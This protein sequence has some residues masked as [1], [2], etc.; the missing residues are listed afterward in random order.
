MHWYYA[1]RGKQAGPIDP[2]TLRRLLQSGQ[3]APTDLVWREGMATWSPAEEVRELMGPPAGAPVLY[4]QNLAGIPVVP[5]SGLAIASLIC[6]IVPVLLSI[7][8]LLGV[9]T[10]IP[11]VICGHASLKSIGSS[12]VPIQGKGMAIA[13]LVTGYLSIGLTVLLLVFVAVGIITSGSG[14]GP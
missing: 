7:G 10:G 8:C 5:T 3:V 1:Q 6:G 13:G 9:I 4:A 12:P 14:G 2:E 11:A